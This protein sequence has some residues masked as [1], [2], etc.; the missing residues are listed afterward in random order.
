LIHATSFVR[1]SSGGPDGGGGSGV[2]AV[3]AV[4]AT[5]AAPPPSSGPGVVGEAAGCGAEQ[6]IITYAAHDA[7]HA[8]PIV[9][10]K[11]SVPTYEEKYESPT[12]GNIPARFRS[13]R[14]AAASLGCRPTS[15]VVD[16]E[17]DEHR[18]SAGP[19][20]STARRGSRVSPT[21][22]IAECRT[23]RIGSASSL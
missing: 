2:A 19:F 22:K 21:K 23:Y 5:A 9:R 6:A 12:L 18:V 10:S 4:L 15:A 3:D 11:K 14:R 13:E 20:L 17:N 16:H 7:S 8:P 1:S